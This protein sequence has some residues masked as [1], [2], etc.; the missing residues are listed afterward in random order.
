MVQNLSLEGNLKSKSMRKISAST[1]VVSMEMLKSDMHEIELHIGVE[2]SYCK[3]RK[4]KI[5][6]K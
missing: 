3:Q 2:G 1:R 5:K 4:N 6:R